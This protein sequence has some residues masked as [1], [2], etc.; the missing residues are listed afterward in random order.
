MGLPVSSIPVNWVDEEGC[1][2]AIRNHGGEGI[3][4]PQGMIMRRITSAQSQ[5]SR[6]IHG[7]MDIAGRA[8]KGILVQ[9]HCEGLHSL[10]F[11]GTV[12]VL[13]HS[14]FANERKMITGAIYLIQWR[15]NL[16]SCPSGALIC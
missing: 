12:F 4:T 7:V 5:S 14:D 2:L 11:K 3:P 15:R 16:K 6:T 8:V 1:C 10:A 13:Q 9:D